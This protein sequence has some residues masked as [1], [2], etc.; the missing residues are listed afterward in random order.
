MI[1]NIASVLYGAGLYAFLALFMPKDKALV[2][3]IGIYL[4]QLGLFVLIDMG[5]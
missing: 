3:A 1:G 5:I 2:S 4:L